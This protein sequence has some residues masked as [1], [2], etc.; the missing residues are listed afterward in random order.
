LGIVEQEGIASQK[1]SS[2]DGE[3][4]ATIACR[5]IDPAALANKCGSPITERMRKLGVCFGAAGRWT[6]QHG[7]SLMSYLPLGA[8][9]QPP[10]ISMG[11]RRARGKVPMSRSPSIIS[12]LLVGI[13]LLMAPTVA[14]A[15]DPHLQ[16]AAPQ[17]SEGCCGMDKDDTFRGYTVELWDEAPTISELNC[18]NQDEACLLKEAEQISRLLRLQEALLSRAALWRAQHLENGPVSAGDFQTE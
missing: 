11:S 6:H 5:V 9:T 15:F 10:H 1:R 18:P 2:S 4:I 14:E 17:A 16:N 8:A 3:D 13:G 12:S 7:R